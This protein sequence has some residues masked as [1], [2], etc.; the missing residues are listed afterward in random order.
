MINTLDIGGNKIMIIASVIIVLCLIFYL[1]Y[2]LKCEKFNNPQDK[3]ESK[4]INI[5]ENDAVLFLF[6]TNW[7]SVC[8]KLNPIWEGFML[9]KPSNVK[10]IE[11]NGDGNNNI[12]NTFNIKGFPTILLSKGGETSKFDLSLALNADK[13]TA[14]QNL[15]DFAK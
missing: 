4:Y 10:I 7:C 9:K 1:I 15:I 5:D 3:Y 8:T 13:T 12:L 14:I 2:R 11:I 6:Y